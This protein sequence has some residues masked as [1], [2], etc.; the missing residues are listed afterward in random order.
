MGSFSAKHTVFRR[1]CKDISWASM[2]P[3]AHLQSYYVTHRESISFKVDVWDLS[4]YLEQELPG[5]GDLA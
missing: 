1:T 4:S 3:R 5:C 2:G